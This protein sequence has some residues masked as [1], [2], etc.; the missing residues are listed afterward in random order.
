ILIAV[1]V[2]VTGQVLAEGSRIFS[3][4]ED[5]IFEIV[6]DPL[7]G[8]V[9]AYP[10]FSVHYDWFIF[11]LKGGPDG[12]LYF[13]DTFSHRIIR[14]DPDGAFWEVVM[15][16]ENLY[17]AEITFDDDGNLYFSNVVCS[18]I[19]V[20]DACPTD[21]AGIWVI[22]NALED[23]PASPRLLVSP[24]RFGVFPVALSRMSIHNDVDGEVPVWYLRQRRPRLEGPIRFVSFSISGAFA[25]GQEPSS[26]AETE[27]TKDFG[28]APG[29]GHATLLVDDGA[30]HEID[31]IHHLGV[32]VDGE[33]DGQP[34]D[35]ATGDD[36][37]GERDDDGVWFTSSLQPG[38]SCFVVVEASADGYLNA[39]LDG[40]ADG[41]WSSTEQVFFMQPL[42]AG[43]NTLTFTVPGTAIEG[44]TVSRFRFSREGMLSF[45]GGAP[46]GE[47][48]DHWVRVCPTYVVA[49]ATDKRTYVVGEEMTVK[50]YVNLASR[51]ELIEERRDGSLRVL[52]SG[53]LE[54]GTQRL[55][56]VPATDQ[57]GAGRLAL[58]ARA[59][60]GNST[61][62]STPYIVEQP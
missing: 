11:D 16:R 57:I 45:D 52:W 46:D 42:N 6:I 62:V 1:G 13:S 31:G 5:T 18:S 50:I 59:D 2:V 56:K 24:E 38:M 17:P 8:L 23:E 19:C 12:L 33:A 25:S 20:G 61:M 21:F 54:A 30:W 37:T 32:L 29:A 27:Y 60:S 35:N 55:V 43:F 47:V 7:T 4:Q 36:L 14:V 41:S 28:D 51:V 48:E 53:D 40:D 44:T 3:H 22:E 10:V 15:E 39:W 9:T 34:N 49:I 58:I 26:L